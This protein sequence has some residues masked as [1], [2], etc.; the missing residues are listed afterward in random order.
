MF[1]SLALTT[2]HSWLRAVMI[3]IN[4][5]VLDFGIH[6]NSLEFA[7]L[8]YLVFGNCYLKTLPILSK[9]NYSPYTLRTAIWVGRACTFT[10]LM[11]AQRPDAC[12]PALASGSHRADMH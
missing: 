9:A 6:L 5:L 2:L 12:D 7:K 4:V 1:I 11:F 8:A 3:S 10:A